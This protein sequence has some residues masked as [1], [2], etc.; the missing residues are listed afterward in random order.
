[1]AIGGPPVT[2]VASG[3]VPMTP[4]AYG[5]GA[6]YTVVA[7]GGFPITIADNAAPAVFLNADGS[8][9][10]RLP[11]DPSFD[12]SLTDR[13]AFLS[14]EYLLSESRIK[15]LFGTF[16]TPAHYATG[17]GALLYSVAANALD[18]FTVPSAV[19]RGQRIEEAR[20]NLL[21]YSN[22]IGAGNWG[23]VNV[24]LADVTTTSPFFGSTTAFRM[25]DDATSGQHRIG[26][27]L[28][29]VT[30]GQNYVGYVIIKAGTDRR[31]QLTMDNTASA[32]SGV[33]YANFDLVS[34]AIVGSGGTLVSSGIIALAEGAYL[35]YIVAA[36]T[37]TTASSGGLSIR[38]VPADNT[39]RTASYS[40][41]GT[42]V[43]LFGAQMG[44]GS[45]PSSFIAT[46]ATSGTRDA[47]SI[48]RTLGSE[49]ST[50]G[51]L[52]LAG[53]VPISSGVT[54]V[55]GQLDDGTDNN[56]IVVYR[57]TDNKLYARVV[58]G[59]ADQANLDLGA[60]S[61]GASIKV[62]MRVEQDNFAASLNGGTVVTDTSG[63]VPAVTSLRP[64]RSVAGTHWNDAVGR[65][66][67]YT[68]KL[69]DAELASITT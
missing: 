67:L 44:L 31:I 9:Y 24:T 3:G 2:I 48:I 57:H 52:Y 12:I 39:T 46:G 62:A 61:A 35:C 66:A 33:G 6:P 32:F 45:F 41:T 1:M 53:R 38:M 43:D 15:A 36:A 51:S 34:G 27:S 22:D 59:G 18:C 20:T 55:L 13:F 10:P 28:V 23:T 56:R 65:A 4:V 63:S 5:K 26:N 29:S 19:C 54:S 58:V 47:S 40:G 69:T 17:T 64:G 42:Y 7:S 16:S 37:A 60:V 30:S 68:A 25:T 50:D 21:V 11:Y 8:E 49:W 14:G